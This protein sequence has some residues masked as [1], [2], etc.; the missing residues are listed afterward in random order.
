[1]KEVKEKAEK[2]FIKVYDDI[3]F[4]IVLYHEKDLRCYTYI[5]VFEILGNVY[6]S[7]QPIY[8]EIGSRSSEDMVYDLENATPLLEGFVKWDGSSQL[9][10]L[11][12]V[13]P[14]GKNEAIQY[15]KLF[16]SIFELVE[17]FN[18]STIGKNEIYYDL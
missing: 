5:K 18:K 8:H 3:P 12:D 6:P 7:K 10:F 16:I 13:C 1:M 4:T 17:E 14:Y 11:E 9:S 2:Y 15:G